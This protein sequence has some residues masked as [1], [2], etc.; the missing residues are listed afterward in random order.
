MNPRSA[1]AAI[2]AVTAVLATALVVTLTERSARAADSSRQVAYFGAALADISAEAC[3]KAGVSDKVRGGVIIVAVAPDG[4]AGKKGLREGDIITEFER[5]PVTAA[6][7]VYAKI[8][9]MSPGEVAQVHAWRD[10]HDRIIDLVQLAG[11]DA[12]MPITAGITDPELA[13]RI[14]R[15]ERLVVALQK[16]VDALEQAQ[17]APR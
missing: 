5:A 1:F 13:D 4:P 8:R 14:D 17:A 12:G 6:W 15:L 10:G 3:R 7:Q 16:R 2:L 9:Q 11:I